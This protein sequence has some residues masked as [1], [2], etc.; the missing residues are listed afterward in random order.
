MLCFYILLLD[1]K[2]MKVKYFS[3]PMRT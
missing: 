3:I 1:F 2:G